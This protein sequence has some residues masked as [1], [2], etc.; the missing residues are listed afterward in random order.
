MRRMIFLGLLFAL[1]ALAPSA[2][3]ASHGPGG[4]PFDFTA[5]GGT[6]SVQNW[7]DLK[8]QVS[9][10]ASEEGVLG[11]A[12][13]RV[14]VRGGGARLA[15][16]VVCMTTNDDFSFVETQD[17]STGLYY[18]ISVRDSRAPGGRGDHFAISGPWVDPIC[19]GDIAQDN[20]FVTSGNLIV[21]DADAM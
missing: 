10:H 12:S 19:G 4:G 2:A 16:Q 3:S 14:N 11:G 17:A 21:H 20:S 9:A 1:G 18:D 6:A 5:G 7:G 8:F 13:G 15:L